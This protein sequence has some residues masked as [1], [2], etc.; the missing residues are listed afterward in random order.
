[1]LVMIGLGGLFVL[2][3]RALVYWCAGR[4]ARGVPAIKT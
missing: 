2:G 3:W 4:R 1:M